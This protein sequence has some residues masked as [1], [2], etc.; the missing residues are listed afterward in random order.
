[1]G[2]GLRPMSTAASRRRC[3]YQS[4]TRSSPTT[5]PI[6]SP[7]IS[8]AAVLYSLQSA[9]QSTSSSRTLSGYDI[10]D[11]IYYILKASLKPMLK[12]FCRPPA[13]LGSP[14]VGFCIMATNSL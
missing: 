12:L 1:V 13:F 7:P 14:S 9:L 5:K 6:A 2:R 4:T 10:L 8:T 3:S 11:A